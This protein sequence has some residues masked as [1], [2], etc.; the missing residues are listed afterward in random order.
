MN[1]SD[2]KSHGKKRKKRRSAL[3]AGAN[4]L[5]PTAAA[6]STSHK[7]LP[8][9]VYSTSSSSEGH[10]LQNFNSDYL[11]SYASDGPFFTTN[12]NAGPGHEAKIHG[13]RSHS[14]IHSTR[15]ESVS[16]GNGIL[17]IPKKK[18]TRKTNKIVIRIPISELLP[19][20]LIQTFLGECN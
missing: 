16:N 19:F 6:Q 17:I 2:L 18:Q 12:D 13:C 7:V 8:I 10:L 4:F 14:F 20:F 11:T 3:R 5:W 9:R 15:S 1:S